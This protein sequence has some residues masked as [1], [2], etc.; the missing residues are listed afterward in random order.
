MTRHP[1]LSIRKTEQ[2]SSARA[3]AQDPQVIQQWFELLDKDL[4][5]AGLKGLPEQIFDVDESG[6]VTDPKYD[7][8][9]ARKGTKK[10]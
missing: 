6:F 5:K 4:T 2:L 1:E 9:I 10:D 3:R 7:I 8:V